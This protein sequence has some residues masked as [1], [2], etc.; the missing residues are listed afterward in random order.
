MTYTRRQI[1]KIAVAAIPVSTL[2]AKPSSRFNGVLIGVQSY[3]FRD[4]PL[5]AALD[6]ITTVGFESVELWQGHVEPKR[7]TP[8]EEMKKWRT[9]PETLTQIKKIRQK[10]DNAGVK[11]QAFNYSFRANNTDEEVEQGME[12]AKALGTKYITASSTVDQAKRLND[13]AGKHGVLIA[14][15]GHDNTKN[16]NEYSTPESFAKAMD[17][18]PNIR[19]NLDIGHF[20]AAGYDP[21][22]YLNEHHDKIVC[23][24]LKDRKKDHGPNMPFGEG[25]TKI[26][27]VLQVLRTKKYNIPANIEYEYKGADAV[28][29]VRKCLE[30]C[31]QALA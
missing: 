10:F 21:V 26:K 19:V 14:M 7:G 9:S 8:P 22:D 18:N 23:L 1:G 29:E 20:T 6:A 17:G 11:I 16:P 4:R 25:E 31:K 24:H 3:S 12:M 2:L 30:Y 15:H 27:E 5:D 13:L 28:E